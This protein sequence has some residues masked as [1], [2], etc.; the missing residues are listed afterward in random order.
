MVSERPVGRLLDYAMRPPH[1]RITIRLVMLA[2]AL[3]AVDL[4]VIVRVMNPK[5]FDRGG[6]GMGGGAYTFMSDG[7]VVLSEPPRPG[8]PGRTYLIR[9]ASRPSP[10]PSEAARYRAWGTTIVT[11]ALSL[12]VMGVAW[13]R[14]GKASNAPQH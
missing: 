13:T 4:A 1:A 9:H 5:P 3:A 6:V 11:V 12:L 8:A 7:S 10:F 14:A 2:V